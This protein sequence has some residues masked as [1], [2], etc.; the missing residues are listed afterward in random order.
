MKKVLT[1]QIG[2]VVTGV[3]LF[4]SAL[5]AVGASGVWTNEVDEL[6]S[7]PAAWL[8][9][10]V[11][12]G[13]GYTAAF[14]NQAAAT[15]MVTLDS[16][17][18]IGNLAF[19]QGTYTIT[20][21]GPLTLAGPTKPVIYVPA[22]SSATIRR[23]ILAGTDGFILDGGG[24]LNIYKGGTATIPADPPNQLTGSVI[25]SNSVLQ[26]QG[27]DVSAEGEPN[28]ND[29]ALDGI[30]SFTFYGDSTLNIRPDASTSPS[31]GTVDADLI[32]P[33]GH[34]GTIILPV[35]FSGSAGD[36]GTIGTGL[37]GSLSG[38]GTLIVRPKYIRGNVVGNWSAFTGQI[39]IAPNSATG[40]GDEFR[41]G[42]SAGF[43]NA[44]VNLSGT[45]SYTARYYP[46]L[47][48]NTVIPIG[49]LIGD[50][51]NAYLAGSMTA[52]Y[53]LFF[54]I[55][56]KQTDPNEVNT[57]P[58]NIVN[59]SGPAGIIWRGAGT[60][61]LTGN[62]TYSG[63]TI[64]S[65][66][67]VQVGDGWSETGAL[68]TGPITNYSK[69]VLARG[70]TLWIPGGIH[71]PGSLTNA[72]PG[73]NVLSGIS[74]Y[75]GP[76][77]ITAGK[78]E[79]GTGSV[80]PG[81]FTVRDEASLG[82]RMQSANGAVR[83]GSL[84]FSSGCTL[85]YEFGPFSN[86]TSTVLTNAGVL[87]MNGNVTVNI[88]GS[89]LGVGSITLLEYSSRTGSG[90]F[91]LGA[92]PANV[93]GAYITD[94][95]LNKR[96][97]LTVTSVL[98]PTLVWVGDAAGVWDVGNPANLVWKVAGSGAQAY[99]TDGNM[100]R[101]DD[102]ATG[103]TTIDISSTVAPS[104]VTVDNSAKD[105]AFG[106]YGSIAGSGTLI[107][108]GTGKLTININNNTWSG[109]TLIESGTIQLGDGTTTTGNL[110][111][112][113]ITNNATLL[114]RQSGDT[115]IGNVIRGTGWVVQEGP[116]QLTLSGA[117]AHT[118]GVIVRSN[119][120]FVN[121]NGD[122][123][124]GGGSTLVLDSAILSM[125][126]DIFSGKTVLVLKD[127]AVLN[128][129]ARRID[130]PIIGTN[131]TLRLTNGAL[132]TF[133]ADLNGFYGTIELDSQTSQ[134][135]R[136]NAGG[137]NTCTGSTNA[138]FY[139]NPPVGATNWLI[140]RNGGTMYLG[141]IA[142]G[143]GRID[144]GGTAVSS[145]LTWVI[146]WLNQ[147]NTW[148]G[149]FTDSART[150]A[151][152]KVGTGKLTLENVA[153][154]HKGA[155]I[156]NNGVLAFKGTTVN[157]PTNMAY[158][159]AE[160]GILDLSEANVKTLTLGTTAFPQTLAGN[161]T[162]RGSVAL[163]GNARLEPGT[164]VGVLTLADPASLRGTIGVLTVTD[165]VTLGGVTLL[166]LNKNASPNSDR[167]VANSIT[168]GGALIVTNI[169]PELAAGDT[170]TLFSR[171]VSGFTS[172]T[173]PPLNPPLYWTNML[174]IDG[175]I[176]VLSMVPTTPTNITLTRIS[177]TQIQLEWPASYIGWRLET[178]AVSITA[179]NQWFTW[180]NSTTTNRVIIDVDQSKTN[181]YF[182][183][184][185]P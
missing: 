132:M 110:G 141:G 129:A 72:G 161:G 66:G 2:I 159:V 17:R 22:G 173:L 144:Q 73:T 140:S 184:V 57:L 53:T 30:T 80:L 131:V 163:A 46:G 152:T 123:V 74:T 127:S 175:T 113:P 154:E 94:D 98:D 128:G 77:V 157:S 36:G 118:G 18:T 169:G 135:L 33:S 60:W 42:N 177:A 126:A 114:C 59:G 76:T 15:V 172:V 90:N 58:A 6:W 23:T 48:S 35:R 107:K 79:L 136:F 44:L 49:M 117:N 27:D 122:A 50:N 148:T 180:V 54:D 40:G 11:A 134:S 185:Y 64:I 34:S 174:A 181:V 12:D 150:N 112:G 88:V 4:S 86:P 93:T 100:V 146:G 124:G 63:P 21:D 103:T 156:V 101:F 158:V 162:I 170:F 62:N 5:T 179:T 143:P 47:A 56:A 78:L 55:G 89:A 31:Y 92:L 149:Y 8:N 147:N 153:L 102:T 38:G 19:I 91:V 87:G 69:L 105:Y 75:T 130:S 24:T 26:V 151:L 16:A 70:G 155:V 43:P 168:G 120:T 109:G 20:N 104:L 25:L 95:T 82:I 29:P 71:G 166:E 83:L 7:N 183:L 65:N 160:P 9:G 176:R 67:I 3:T 106:G 99:Y 52:A 142:G 137:A 125:T 111:S 32:V 68:G 178:N 171:P 85:D 139:F 182:R 145:T 119:A 45:I 37:G 96:V 1:V 84:T 41:F 81:S 138:L 133:T 167:L 165:T 61:V 14:S 13:A 121:A 97:V 28:A 108:R 115:T 164:A 116:G 39:D 10:V 51:A